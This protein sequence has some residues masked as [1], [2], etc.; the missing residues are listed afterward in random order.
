MALKSY[1][2]D[3]GNSNKGPIGMCARVRASSKAQAL[4]LLQAALPQEVNV[5]A[6]TAEP[7]E[8]GIEY[9][10]IYITADNIQTRHV[11]DIEPVDDE[12][13]EIEAE[14]EEDDEPVLV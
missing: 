4:E 3:M 6:E 10:E 12:D 13:D 9:I 5:D 8:A 7:G 11:D 14:E 1:H 2:F